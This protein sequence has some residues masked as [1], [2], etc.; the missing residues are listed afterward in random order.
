MDISKCKFCSNPARY[1]C[2]C[3][4][5][6]IDFCRDHL[7]IHENSSGNH[8]IKLHKAKA[9]TPNPLVKSALIERISQVRHEAKEK[10]EQL[11]TSLN[12]LILRMQENYDFVLEKLNHFVNVCD[13]VIEE[14]DLI[15]SVSEKLVL[16]PLEL[17]LTSSDASEVI[18]KIKSPVISFNKENGLPRYTPSVFPYFLYNFSDLSIHTPEDQKI[19]VYPSKKEINHALISS[20]MRIL[21]IGNK[22][23]LCTG[24]DPGDEAITSRCFV[25]N[26]ESE[27]ISEFPCLKYP[28]RSHSMTWI[29][30]NPAVIGG[31]DN[32]KQMSSVEMFKNDKWIDMPPINIARSIHSSVCT[33]QHVW[34]IGGSHGDKYLDSIEKYERDSWSILKLKLAI[35]ASFI[36]ACS[37]ENNLILFGGLIS[38]DCRINNTFLI[39]IACHRITELIP[40]H[41][42][43][44]FR[45]NSSIVDSEH[46]FA[47]GFW[48]NDSTV[49]NELFISEI[50][51]M[52]TDI[53]YL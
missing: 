19:N 10:A 37:L 36:G 12:L 14:I 50:N 23:I 27:E 21:N 11:L 52:S 31:F 22:R 7:D 39:D 2:I 53:L 15:Q 49:M 42:S 47:V 13:S 24:G 18:A 35:P 5:P 28:R 48:S 40:I 43:M 9:L 33:Q 26:V 4:S 46:I 25:L 32:L 44:Y 38:E 30:R 51:L 41:N 1:Y 20:R 8:K 34:V 29:D 6:S 16:C 17:L 45:F 3:V